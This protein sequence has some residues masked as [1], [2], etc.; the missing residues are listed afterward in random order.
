MGAA[1]SRLRLPRTVTVNRCMRGCKHHMFWLHESSI[2]VK[3]RQVT[4][5]AKATPSM[6][7]KNGVLSRLCSTATVR[8][9]HQAVPHWTQTFGNTQTGRLSLES[10]VWKHS[11]RARGQWQTTV[12]D[13]HTH[14]FAD[15]TSR[16]LLC[17][18]RGAHYESA[19]GGHSQK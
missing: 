15:G 19:R 18:N 17:V 1:N 3:V 14:F 2:G 12:A 16:S 5:A 8:R 9:F 4:A 6:Q 10:I 11:K 13:A 7:L